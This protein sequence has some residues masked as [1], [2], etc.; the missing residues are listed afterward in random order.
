MLRNNC[1]ASYYY[2]VL[3]RFQQKDEFHHFSEKKQKNRRPNTVGS[4]PSVVCEE[5]SIISYCFCCTPPGKRWYINQPDFSDVSA[6]DGSLFLLF[7][8]VDFV[9]CLEVVYDSR[10]FGTSRSH[11]RSITSTSPELEIIFFFSLPWSKA[12]CKV[13]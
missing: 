6:L 7:L 13:Q 3:E 12:S 5:K 11:T 8:R 10:F 1:I 4:N 9:C 2:N